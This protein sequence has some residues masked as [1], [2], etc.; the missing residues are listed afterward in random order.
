MEAI[1][2]KSRSGGRVPADPETMLKTKHRWSPAM[3]ETFLRVLAETCCVVAAH[4]A[5]GMC[6]TSLYRRRGRDAAFA[7]LWDEALEEG[8]AQLEAELLRRARFGTD[9]EKITQTG[10]TVTIR[11]ISD[12]LGLALLKLHRTRVTQIRTET[13][14]GQADKA[15]ARSKLI[16]LGL[17][18]I[19]EPEA[20][21]AAL[22]T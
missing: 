14:A 12:R 8:Y 6:S 13:V 2:V 21:D 20:A 18:L 15:A 7:A 10:E 16:D 4:R 17:R 1:M 19:G 9:Q 5:I 11:V 3:E 22:V